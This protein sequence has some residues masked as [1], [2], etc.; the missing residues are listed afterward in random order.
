MKTDEHE[1]Y[2]DFEPQIWHTLS[3]CPTVCPEHKRARK[4]SN[5][6][7]AG[8]ANFFSTICEA[9]ALSGDFVRSLF[10]RP[11]PKMVVVNSVQNAWGFNHFSRRGKK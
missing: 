2:I 1:R 11:Q 5:K 6:V 7:I 4:F 3:I 8:K 10:A 9:F